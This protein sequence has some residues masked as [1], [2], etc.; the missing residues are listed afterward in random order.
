[1]SQMDDE[2]EHDFDSS[3][4]A[5][6][7]HT[8][9]LLTDD[10]DD[11]PLVPGVRNVALY[12]LDALRAGTAGLPAAAAP[13]PVAT[14]AAAVGEPAPERQADGEILPVEPAGGAPPPTFS[15]ILAAEAAE[16]AG[17]DPVLG[18]L[19]AAVDQAREDAAKAKHEADVARSQAM[20]ADAQLRVA[21][22]VA[23]AAER[24]AVIAEGAVK[25][26]EGQGAKDTSEKSRDKARNKQKE[27]VSAY[28][29]ALSDVGE[30]VFKLSSAE[31]DEI[32]K[33]KELRTAQAEVAKE[34]AKLDAVDAED[35]V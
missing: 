2:K 26:A 8:H 10:P 25:A 17:N 23:R 24:A 13:V 11:R 16:I 32:A 31:R 18:R 4:K 9:G 30:K 28:Q 14:A 20:A 1:M 7:A 34:R 12:A 6:N 29:K 15:A 35:D 5:L 21:D 19:L 3:L 27:A 22:S 33:A